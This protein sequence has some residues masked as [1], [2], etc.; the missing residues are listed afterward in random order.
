MIPRAID[1]VI[2][3]WSARF[4]GRVMPCAVG[5]NGLGQKQ[6]EGD[7]ITPF[8]TFQIEYLWV[9]RDRISTQ[10]RPKTRATGLRDQWCEDPD[11]ADYNL[12][13][14]SLQRFGSE[15]LR[16]PDRLYDVVAVLDYNR[17]PVIPGKGSA[18]FLHLW[19]KP[20]HP[21]AGCVAF[22]EADLAW[23][24]QHWTDHSKVIIR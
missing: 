19:R 13:V 6:V 15:K 23:I 7:K 20:R 21:T 16:R 17:N 14:K 11:A 10:F 8:G 5:R 1:L 12:P 2:G 24:L 18:I 9:R 4:S 22:A 3:Q